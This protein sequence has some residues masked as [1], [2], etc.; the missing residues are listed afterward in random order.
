MKNVAY[1]VLLLTALVAC[2]DREPLVEVTHRSPTQAASA[3][4]PDAPDPIGPI[5]PIS[6]EAGLTPV[7][8]PPISLAALCTPIASAT[9]RVHLGCRS[10]VSREAVLACE[11]HMRAACEAERPRLGARVASERLRFDAVALRDCVGH[12][13]LLGCGAAPQ[14]RSRSPSRA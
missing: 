13:D 14:A 4:T 10:G 2:D 8:P 6:A 7:V 9:C 11:D 3:G 1:I 12:L 5:M